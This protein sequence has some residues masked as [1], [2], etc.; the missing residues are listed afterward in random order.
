MAA[1]KVKKILEAWLGHSQ[2]APLFSVA[3]SSNR[4]QSEFWWEVG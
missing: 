4:V 2:C 3:C 1:D